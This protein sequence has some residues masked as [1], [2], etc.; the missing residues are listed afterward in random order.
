MTFATRKTAVGILFVV[1]A[2]FLAFDLQASAPLDP[3]RAP[4]LF[5][6]GSGEASS[7]AHCAAGIGN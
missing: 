5:A 2:G 7:G 4:A 6:L 3:F 1:L